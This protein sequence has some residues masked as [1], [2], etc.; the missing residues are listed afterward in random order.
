MSTV[1]GQD[2]DAGTYTCVVTSVTGESSWSGVLTVRGDPHTL[3]VALRTLH[4]H[5]LHP[6]SANCTDS[7]TSLPQES[8]KTT[9]TTREKRSTSVVRERV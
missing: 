2:A 6:V 3:P 4:T 8:V 1:V 9:T 7:L 5:P